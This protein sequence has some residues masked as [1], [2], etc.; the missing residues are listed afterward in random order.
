MNR[1]LVMVAALTLALT[2]CS[3]RW[4]PTDMR[5]PPPAPAL[6]FKT[7]AQEGWIEVRGPRVEG[8]SA[9]AWQTDP[10]D[11]RRVPANL[12]SLYW[13]GRVLMRDVGEIEV[14]DLTCGLGCTGA[15]GLAAAGIVGVGAFYL[16]IHAVFGGLPG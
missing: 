9:I 8:D 14:G 13:A 10:R 6:R 12:G 15:V 7:V 2:G 11:A 4:T 1:L 3:T 5:P 16:F